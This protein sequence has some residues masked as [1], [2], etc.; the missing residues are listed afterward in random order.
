MRLKRIWIILI[1]AM[2]TG[3][4]VQGLLTGQKA[5]PVP[6]IIPGEGSVVGLLIDSNGE[7]ISGKPV[8]LAEVYRSN[9]RIAYLVDG[10]NNPASV[11]TK[12]GNFKFDNIAACEYVIWVGNLMTGYQIIQDGAGNPQIQVV[13][14]GSE[15]DLG[16]L[17]IN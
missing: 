17:Q 15:L 4:K 13:Q 12:V 7:P 14:G 5:I 1:L 10:G 9:D 11:T 2:L 8:H 3:C 6:K 16:E